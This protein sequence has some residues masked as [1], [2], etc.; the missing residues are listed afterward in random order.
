MNKRFAKA[1]PL[2]FL[3]FGGI[4]ECNL[5]VNVST[6]NSRFTIA[7]D[8]TVKDED[9]KLIWMRCSLGQN[10]DGSGCTG[11]ISSHNW[12]SALNAA[13]DTDFAGVTD[14]R[15][16]NIKELSS[17]IEQQCYNPSINESLFPGTPAEQYWTSSPYASSAKYGWNVSFYL[18]YNHHNFKTSEFYVRLVRN[19]E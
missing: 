3:S 11:E 1:L 10:W 16:P 13:R 18:G 7:N 4:A 19:A 15:L 14:W 17:I 5:N 2:L 9:T 8:G 12:Q 6:P